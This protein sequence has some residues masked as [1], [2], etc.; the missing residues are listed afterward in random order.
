LP[1]YVLYAVAVISIAHSLVA[2]AFPSRTAASAARIPAAVGV[3]A[4]LAGAGWAVS[5]ARAYLSYDS[6][7][8]AER[9]AALARFLGSGG[10]VGPDAGFTAPPSGTQVVSFAEVVGDRPEAGGARVYTVQADTSRLGT[11]YLAVTV[12]HTDAGR[13]DLVGAPAL[14]AAPISAPA[15]TDS[16]AGG[17]VSDPALVRVVSGAL[18]SYLRGEGSALRSE[19]APGAAL[20][21]P[22]VSLSGVQVVRIVWAQRGRVVGVDVRASD[23]LGGGYGLHYAVSVIR[24]GG[25]LVSGIESISSSGG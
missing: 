6:A 21:L 11:V 25:W 5:F 18:V 4:D 2:T 10:A 19:L 1:R 16:Q 17:P 3:G 24:R 22:S 9:T 7:D 14:I 23:R 15:V 20:S 8:P 12:A 13:L